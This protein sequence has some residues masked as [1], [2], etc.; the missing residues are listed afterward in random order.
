LRTAEKTKAERE[1]N[2]RRRNTKKMTENLRIRM[3]KGKRANGEKGKD[4]SLE[5]PKSII[6]VEQISNYQLT[7]KIPVPWNGQLNICN[8]IE[9]Y[10]DNNCSQISN[11]ETLVEEK[12]TLY[13]LNLSQ[14]LVCVNMGVTFNRAVRSG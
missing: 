8:C 13:I 4:R 5:F 9:A 2:S 6:Y 3:E 14:Y 7:K 12:I 1:V 10:D 11:E